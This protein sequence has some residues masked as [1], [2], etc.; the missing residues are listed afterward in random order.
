MP[1]G[2]LY[3]RKLFG[4]NKWESVNG[5]ICSIGSLDLNHILKRRHMMFYWRPAHSTSNFLQ[6]ILGCYHGRRPGAEF[7]GGRK[8]FRGSNFPNDLFRK[9]FPFQ[10]RNFFLMTF[11]SHRPFFVCLLPGLCCL[12]SDI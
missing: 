5:V 4:F 8:K 7:W 3:Y 2:I 12:T 6:D 11:F 1:V 10:R 9:K